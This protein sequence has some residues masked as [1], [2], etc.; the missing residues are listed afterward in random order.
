MLNY[1]PETQRKLQTFPKCTTEYIREYLRLCLSF[2][3]T[4]PLAIFSL[5]LM[6]LLLTPIR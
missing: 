4:L 2:A 5:F 6:I 1:Q 3:Q